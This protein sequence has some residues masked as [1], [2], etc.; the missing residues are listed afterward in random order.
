LIS[1]VELR[2]LRAFEAVVTARTIT[3]AAA[4][5]GL[6]PSSVSE[7]IR[8][9]E[10]SLGTSLFNRGPR[11]MRLTPAGERLLP[12]ARRIRDLA[13]Q[14]RGEV[15]GTGPVLR[16]G[17]LETIAATHVPGVLAQF[18]RQR[19][20]VAVEVR[21]ETAR[22]R[23]LAA[24]GDG[25]LDAALVLDLG[26]DVGGLGFTVPAAPLDFVDL[27]Q[28]PLALVAA[29]DHRLAG[30]A[31]VTRDDLHG[32]KLLVNVPACSFWLAG[33]RLLGPDIPRVQAGSVAVMR[34]WAERGLGI[35]LLPRFA[36][37]DQL[38]AGTLTKLALG[39]P[40]LSLRLV[41]RADHETNPGV[42][43]LLYAASTA[44]A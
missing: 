13:E 3:D 38:A 16:L 1:A 12:W 29:P 7:Q 34:A 25:E 9:L 20:E 23:L 22:D 19:P 28:V 30:A 17:A 26:D 41:W 4:A 32:E 42:R 27:Q 43:R 35:S 21:S 11:G 15:A 10:R 14:A 8:T 33:Q 5:L 37:A 6:A 36:V 40:D 2:Q 39:A 24:V 31:R 44:M 18:A